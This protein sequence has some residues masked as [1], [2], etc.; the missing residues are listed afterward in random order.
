MRIAVAGGT[1]VVGRYVVTAA[2]RVGHDVVVLSRRSGVDVQRGE[3]LAEALAGV[4]VVVDTLN[5]MAT[6]RKPAER[7]F[8]ETA[9]NL[10]SA[11]ARAGVGH[12]VL[13]S[14][15][16]IDRASG[17]GY[18]AAKLAQ[19]QVAQAGPVPVTILRATQFHEFPAQM[20]AMT[21][22]GPIAVVA[23]MR[24]QPVAARTVGEH[25]VR[26]AEK[27]PGGIVELAG[28]EVFEMPDLARRTLA[29]RGIKA[30]VVAVPVPGSAA[31][32]MAGDALLAGP[33]TTIDGP[34]FDDWL[35]T[36]DARAVP[37]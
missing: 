13:L 8:T 6:R 5:Q 11:A 15:V 28:P 16:G 35:A 34:R 27:Q 36:E 1:G 32:A 25:L 17:Y 20:L 30:K 7:F 10:Q 18:Y 37:L 33:G 31:K 14:I 22:K 3:G 9:R 21:R 12:I 29:A 19:E 24:S 4:D 2:E 26:L 23:K